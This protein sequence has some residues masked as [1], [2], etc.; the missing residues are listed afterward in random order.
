MSSPGCGTSHANEGTPIRLE[1]QK[2]MEY[3][4]KNRRHCSLDLVEEVFGATISRALA[5]EILLGFIRLGIIDLTIDG[6]APTPDQV[7]DACVNAHNTL[8]SVL[9][10]TKCHT[11]NKSHCWK[12]G[13]GVA[14]TG[15]QNTA[16]FLNVV[17]VIAYHIASSLNGVTRLTDREITTLWTHLSFPNCRFRGVRG[18]DCRPDLIAIPLEAFTKVKPPTAKDED[19]RSS[20]CDYI[21][22]NVL[23]KAPVPC[24]NPNLTSNPTQTRDHLMSST[25]GMYFDKEVLSKYDYAYVNNEYIDFEK[26]SCTG[27]VKT[28]E[29]SNAITQ[30]MIYMEQQRLAQPQRHFV[31]GLAVSNGKLTLSRADSMGT[32][33]CT[34]SLNCGSGI[35]EAIRVILGFAIANQED[36]GQ[37]PYFER[38]KDG[39]SWYFNTPSE[40]SQRYYLH[41]LTDNRGSLVGRMTRV[42]CAYRQVK[43][44]DEIRKLMHEDDQMVVKEEKKKWKEEKRKNKNKNNNNNNKKKRFFV[45]PY[46]LKI[47]YVDR[48]SI[49]YKEGV[50]EQIKKVV[51]MERGK[52]GGMV[53]LLLPE[54]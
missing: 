20:L 15:E 14:G 25:A 9:T 24:P 52:T 37:S 49:N 40:P 54:E 28:S 43:T 33:E 18:Q 10:E 11:I 35:L 38:S 42:W 6:K 17:A 32:E 5:T 13:P 51:E 39:K 23:T 1:A 27:E 3:H 31:L 19:Q 46:T 50:G 4:L 26:L 44:K 12:W 53:N 21:R 30:E 41:H 36:F 47:Q 22:N 2:F 29:H 48:D 45:G 8:H 34:L 16:R 7:I